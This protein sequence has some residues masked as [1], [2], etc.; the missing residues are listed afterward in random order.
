MKEMQLARGFILLLNV[1]NKT[2][3]SVIELHASNKFLACNLLLRIGLMVEG[4][5]SNVSYKSST[6]S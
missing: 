3:C 4:S 2:G 5:Q 6:H 1:S